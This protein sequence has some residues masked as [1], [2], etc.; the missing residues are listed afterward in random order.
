MP[1]FTDLPFALNSLKQQ[2]VD[3]HDTKSEFLGAI[4]AAQIVAAFFSP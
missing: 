3:L 4:E 2:V 1:V